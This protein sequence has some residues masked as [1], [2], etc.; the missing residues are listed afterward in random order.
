M[1][2]VVLAVLPFDN[3]SSDPNEEYF[4]DG[5][6]DALIADLAQIGTLRVISR[7]S[8]MQ[9]KRTR[10]PLRQIAQALKA[11]VIVEGAVLRSGS[12]V[13]VTAQLIDATTDQHLWS[14]KYERDLRDILSLQRELA[15]DIASE[16]KVELA[17]QEKAR[18]ATA[19]AVN[20][21]AHEAYLRGRH[22]WNKR[23]KE[24]VEKAIQYFQEAIHKEP[25]SALAYAGLADSYAVMA[26]WEDGRLSPRKAL[27][28]TKAAASRALELDPALAEAHT[29]L[30]VAK[31]EYDWDWEGAERAF[32][33]AIA[34]NPSYATA[35]HWYA[36][37][38][39]AMGRHEEALEQSKRAQQLDP[40]SPII[41]SSI[42]YQHYLSGQYDQAIEQYRQALEL[43][44]SFAVAHF[45]LGLV[46]E[47]KGM[48]AEAVAELK[49]SLALSGGS[50]RIKA[51][52]GHAYGAAGSSIEAKQIVEELKQRSRHTRISADVIALV[53]AGLRE[54]DEAFK[55]LER[56]FAER[57]GSLPYLNADPRFDAL[58]LDPRFQDL[59][60]S[61]GLPL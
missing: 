50:A 55:W 10:M 51:A 7:T 11:D 20:P 24:G 1:T 60:T 43:D 28:K 40:F 13:R 36:S 48:F 17:P 34:L 61:I 42:G 44:P 38:L 35:R 39:A 47:Q 30:A 29:S 4:A 5:M 37:Y 27:S 16:I 21:E 19:A 41:K 6:T 54:K 33:R 59:I 23:S 52:L 15:R 57:S 31:M 22:C 12:R 18:L 53:F 26:Y 56:A 3:L 45:N 49:E 14:Q 9:Y 8:A 32:R 58:R 46:Y 25:Q 2:L